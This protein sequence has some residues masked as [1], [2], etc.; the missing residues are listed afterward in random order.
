VIVRI[1]TEPLEGRSVAMAVAVAMLVIGIVLIAL[2]IQRNSG[3]LGT[4]G[5]FI[6]ALAVG[7]FFPNFTLASRRAFASSWDGVVAFGKSA[8]TQQ[9]TATNLIWLIVAIIALVAAGA[10]AKQKKWLLVALA[11]IL[12]GF[13]ILQNFPNFGSGLMTWVTTAFSQP[14]FKA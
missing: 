14:N 12:F 3:G 10:F 1:Q 9:L 6:T 8:G 2:G 11:V 7:V 4:A 13:A 5:G